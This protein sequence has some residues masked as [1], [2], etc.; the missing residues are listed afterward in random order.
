MS[1]ANATSPARPKG[2]R[3]AGQHEILLESGTNEVEILVFDLDHEQY[4]V[5]VAKV[6]EVIRLPKVKPVPRSNELLD[7]MLTLRE[8][9]VPLYNLRKYFNLPDAPSDVEEIVMITEFS[10]LRA[11]FRVDK[12]DRI[13]RVS[14]RGIDSV[15]AAS[16]D[17]ESAITAIARMGDNLIMMVDFE[18]FIMEVGG[19][20]DFEKCASQIEDAE[21]QRQDQRVL[22]AE[23]S[24]FMR[25]TIEKALKKAGYGQLVS[26]NDGKEAWDWLTKNTAA[27]E[28]P[29]VDIV[30]TDIE[31]PKMDGLN[32]TKRIKDHPVLRTLPVIVFSS[33]VSP[34]NEKKCRAV[35]ADM[36]ITK[37]E[38]GMLVSRMDKLLKS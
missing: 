14:Y 15:P 31:M 9:V 24:A 10:N 26:M 12:V 23:D 16:G 33:L 19:I 28:K 6:R 25:A 30:I 13:H 17:E 37:P 34:D 2:A 8:D 38:L 7:G 5:N 27:G 18:R 11:A 35:G 4:G 3:K 22:H 21:F 32:L 36:Q 29:P 20:Q 1:A